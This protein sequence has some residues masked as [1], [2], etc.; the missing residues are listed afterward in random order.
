MNT[1]LP[2]MKK[3]L[4]CI[5]TSKYINR[6][7]IVIGHSLS[8]ALAMRLAEKNKFSK[9]FL[10][11]GWDYDDLFAP[12]KLFWPNKI[13]HKKIKIN[14]KEIF[15]VTSDNDPYTTAFQTNEMNKRLNGK[16]ILIKK[17]G[18]F[19]EKDKCNKIPQLLD[20]L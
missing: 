7:T 16:F 20:F 18:H 10:I 4:R 13:N 3:M 2:D 8:C 15:C 5:D 11:A 17:A 14:V 9:M 6:E 12:H 19:G 1:N